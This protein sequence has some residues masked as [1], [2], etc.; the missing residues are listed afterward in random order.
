MS[1]VHAH[2]DTEEYCLTCCSDGE[3]ELDQLS[4]TLPRYGEAL[5]WAE[6]QFD[7][8]DGVE[9]LLE[10]DGEDIWDDWS[11]G[12]SASL[13][14][15]EDVGLETIAGLLEAEMY[16]QVR[17]T[18]TAFLEEVLK[19]EWW[20]LSKIGTGVA[21]TAASVSYAMGSGD[22]LVGEIGAGLSLTWAGDGWKMLHN[23]FGPR[24]IYEGVK[25]IATNRE[26]PPR[27]QHERLIESALDDL[28]VID[29]DYIERDLGEIDDLVQQYGPEEL[30]ERGIPLDSDT[31][32]MVNK[33]L[34]SDLEDAKYLKIVWDPTEEKK[35]LQQVVGESFLEQEFQHP[36]ALF[37]SGYGYTPNGYA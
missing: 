37:E 18:R 5:L 21:G 4:D 6:Q 7:A 20:A 33:K 16:Q 1:D 10:L 12:A 8:E 28:Y 15:H 3:Y 11:I 26:L 29:I 30:E 19:E 25:H 2:G 13:T 24:D 9:D 31:Y 32:N 36:A 17:S 14:V 23:E 35:Y 22:P 34:D 27:A